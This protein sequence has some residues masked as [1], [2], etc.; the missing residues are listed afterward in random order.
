MKVLLNLN[1]KKY[2]I[3]NLWIV[4]IIMSTPNKFYKFF[5]IILNPI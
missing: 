5:V 3:T 1:M 2:G 4:T